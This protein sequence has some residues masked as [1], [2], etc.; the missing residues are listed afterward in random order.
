MV[1]CW[2]TA[3][4]SLGSLLLAFGLARLLGKPSSS[5]GAVLT[6]YKAFSAEPPAEARARMA[7]TPWVRWRDEILAELERAH[8]DIRTLTTRLDV[9]LLGHAM[10]IPTPGLVWGSARLAAISAR[11][12]GL[13]HFAHSDLSALPLLEEAVYWGSRVATEV[14]LVL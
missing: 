2:Q 3:R 14:A 6:Y 13:V 10:T 9:R 1:D 12:F 7:V 8:P 4:T 5:G 11:P